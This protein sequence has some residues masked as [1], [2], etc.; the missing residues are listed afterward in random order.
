MTEAV[1]VSS[2]SPTSQWMATVREYMPP[3]AGPEGVAERLILIL[4]YSIDWHLSWVANYRPTYWDKILPDRI[5]VASQQATN[6]R[7]WWTALADDFSASPATG[8]IR[9]ELAGLLAAEEPERVLLSLS[10][11]TLALVMR[12]RIVAE[13]R[14]GLREE[15]SGRD[16]E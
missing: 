13:A 7:S 6:L 2:S 11:E 8:E 14:R 9:R 3:L 16:D 15:L 1:A 12:V 4:H 10:E 5:L